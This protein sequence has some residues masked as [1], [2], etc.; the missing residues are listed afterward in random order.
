MEHMNGLMEG[1]ML[2]NGKII[3]CIYL[4]IFISKN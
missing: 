4:I 1:N 3:K 2:V